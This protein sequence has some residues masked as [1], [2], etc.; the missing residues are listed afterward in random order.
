MLVFPKI[1][2]ALF[3]ISVL[4]FALL[5]HYRGT[6]DAFQLFH[7]I[8]HSSS[9]LLSISINVGV[10]GSEHNQTCPTY[11][12]RRMLWKN[13]C[14]GVMIKLSL[15]RQ[16]KYLTCLFL[17]CFFLSICIWSYPPLKMCS[18]LE[19][20]LQPSKIELFLVK[21]VLTFFVS[22]PM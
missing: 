4:S 10:A 14:E 2:L 8:Y 17:C 6:I 5:P 3:V 13:F 21:Q 22:F 11:F 20:K 12:Q 18:N 15:E 1:W 19:R 9:Q 16:T 7:T